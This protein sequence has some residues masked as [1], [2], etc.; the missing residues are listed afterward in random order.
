MRRVQ[1]ENLPSWLVQ[2]ASTAGSAVLVSLSPCLFASRVCARSQMVCL[3]QA[4]D[5][6][7]TGTTPES[8]E[9]AMVAPGVFWEWVEDV[10]GLFVEYNCGGMLGWGLG[11][12]G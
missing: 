4:S 5:T 6:H 3:G 9:A 11:R 2:A 7:S 1:Y 8:F 10:T 12:P